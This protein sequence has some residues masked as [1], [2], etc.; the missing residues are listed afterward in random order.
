[1]ARMERSIGSQDEDA[2][3]SRRAPDAHPSA[4]GGPAR[5]GTQ[6]VDV[7]GWLDRLPP[8]ARANAL[9]ASFPR[10]AER[11]ASLDNEPPLASRYLDQLMID[12]R[13]DRQGFPIEVGRELMRLRCHYAERLEQAIVQSADSI[14]GRALRSGAKR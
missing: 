9:V 3:A 11:I 6:V 12:Q 14:W 8:V 10:I 13:G 7:Q 4:A 5:P 2:A 1:M